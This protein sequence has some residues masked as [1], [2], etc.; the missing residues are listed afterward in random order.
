MHQIQD[1][2]GWTEYL[3]VFLKLEYFHAL[4]NHV[5]S[6]IKSTKFCKDRRHQN[7]KISDLLLDIVLRL[8]MV[9][10][11]KFRED[12]REKVWDGLWVYQISEVPFVA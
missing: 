11:H 5:N 8:V 10:R 6:F 2:L 12:F 4:A 9:S 7:D 3:S 1:R